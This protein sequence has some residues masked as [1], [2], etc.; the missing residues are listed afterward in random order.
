MSLAK[1]DMPVK[2][3][4]IPPQKADRRTFLKVAAGI[5]GAAVFARPA[6][7][8]TQEWGGIR[9]YLTWYL[10]SARN[11][12]NGYSHA[13][14]EAGERIR[15]YFDYLT[16]DEAGVARFVEEY[17]KYAGEVTIVSVHAHRGMFER[18]LLSTDFFLNGADESRTVRYLALHDPYVSPCWA[19]FGRGETV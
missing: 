13:H 5:A 9:A 2:A 18:F 11:H 4:P 10:R 7:A 6:F 8:A 15:K 14:R 12:L 19:P 3:A 16:L 17:E 1:M